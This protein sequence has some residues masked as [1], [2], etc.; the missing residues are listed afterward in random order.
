MTLSLQTRAGEQL[1]IRRGVP[2]DRADN[3]G[4]PLRQQEPQPRHGALPREH[5]S[6]FKRFLCFYE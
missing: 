4:G 6:V 3:G 1:Q 2:A 5:R